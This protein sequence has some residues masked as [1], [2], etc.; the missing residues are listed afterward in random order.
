MFSY[1]V[2]LALLSL[3]RTP[4]LSFLMILLIAMGIGAT[5][6]TYTVSY[7]MSKDPIP[8]KSNQLFMLQMD[9]YP[10]GYSSG[11]DDKLN[12]VLSYQDATNLMGSGIPQGETL[13]SALK[14]M[15]KN[16]QLQEPAL[17]STVR[18]T[19]A[20]FFSMF[21]AP[22]LYGSAWGPLA[23]QQAEQV[24]VLTKAM[25]DRLFN[26]EN[27]VGQS[28]QFGEDL[29][30][31]VGVLDNWDPLPKFYAFSTNAYTAPYD[32]FIP[33][34]VQIQKELYTS[35]MVSTICWQNPAD[36]SYAAFLASECM[37]VLYWAELENQ[38]TKEQFQAYVDNYATD[39][40]AYGRFGNRVFNKLVSVPEYL[41]E[42]EVV[43]EDSKMAVWLAA[44]FLLVCLLNCMGLMLAKFHGK[45]GEIGLRRAVGAS[46]QQIVAQFSVEL[47][48]IGIL[49][50]VAGLL[51]AQL[52]LN[53]TANTYSYLHAGL[54]QMNLMLVSSTLVL[55]V[56]VSCVFGLY[57]IV[58]AS[59][60]QPSSQLKS[61]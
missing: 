21:E 35:S 36:D 27:S 10:E 12:P 60:T 56:I 53:A 6:T 4:L 5:M 59:R 55:A 16:P 41:V 61:L 43:S 38:Q 48:V 11:D 19:T 47:M 25:N 44:L 15:V 7:M 29:Y 45:A 46:K 42:R 58:K 32:V 57:P 26:G 49:G 22:F 51:L 23:D 20:D 9:S 40:Q 24:I 39:Q 18:T 54:M 31:I 1:Y 33:F 34:S 3:K 8:N 13:L 17:S 28:V 37:W 50:G 52:G 30:Q 14:A 2:K